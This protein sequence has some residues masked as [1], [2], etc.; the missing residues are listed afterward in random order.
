MKKKVPIQ[1][2][3]KKSLYAILKSEKVF[4]FYNNETTV[5]CTSK[6]FG[7]TFGFG[8]TV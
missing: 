8:L 4:H 2:H 7:V 5:V 1:T 3:P 6:M